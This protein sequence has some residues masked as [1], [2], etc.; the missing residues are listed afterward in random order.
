LTI[1]PPEFY[2]QGDYVDL[3]LVIGDL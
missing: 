1:G 3:I 2:N